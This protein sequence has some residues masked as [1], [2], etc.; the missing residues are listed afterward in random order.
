VNWF[1]KDAQGRWLWPGYGE[2]SRVLE[3]IFDRVSGK[4]EAVETPIGWVP[5]P[6]AINL[7]GTQVTAADMEELLSVDQDEWKAEVP[8]I[9]EHY[10][11]FGDR[12]PKTLA[13]T[14]DELEAKLAH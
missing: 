1:R 2:N 13:R 12:I 14:V 7:E 11:R 3:W 10:A 4:A 9:R 8:L 5:V 6:G